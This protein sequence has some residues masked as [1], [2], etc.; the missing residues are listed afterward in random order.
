MLRFGRRLG[1]AVSGGADSVCLLH[2]MSE[3]APESGLALVVL[4]VNH[5]LRGEESNAEALFV[6]DLAARLGHESAEGALDPARLREGNVEDNARQ[7]RI[8]WF[9]RWRRELRLDAVAVGHTR[10]DQ[11]ET[12]L[13][14]LIRGAGMEGLAGIEPVTADRRIR[15]LIE[16]GRDEV[17]RWLK[18]RGLEWREDSSNS[19][20]HLV[21]NRVRGELLPLLARENPEIEAVLGRLAQM[22]WEDAGYW[23]RLTARFLAESSAREEGAVCLGAARLAALEPSVLRRVLR[24]AVKDVR[25]DLSGLDWVHFD[26]LRRLVADRQ[27]GE[28]QLPGAA[29][30]RSLG[31]VRVAQPRSPE[32]AE[33]AIGG[34]GD[35]RLGAQGPVIRLAK[36]ELSGQ[37]GHGIFHPGCR[38]NGG[39][40]LLDGD[41]ITFPLVLRQ[42]RPGDRYQPQGARREYSLKELFQRARVPRWEREGWPVIAAGMRIVWAR[43]FGAAGWAAAAPGLLRAFEVREVPSGEKTGEA[44]G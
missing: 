28:A 38:Y 44:A 26:E 24:G 11:A 39:R 4:H 36:V 10:S 25:G 32:W 2:L 14:R 12:V 18:R 20:A 42:W 19:S 40:H 41:L 16:L 35:F 31:W 21:R 7:G 6:R 13:M 1:V 23:E 29:A 5:G 30:C 37:Q 22:A 3:L 34:E 27:D 8:E 43:R 33:Q 9:A 17:R 15:P